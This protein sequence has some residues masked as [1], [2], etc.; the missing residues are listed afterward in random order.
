MANETKET[1]NEV[2]N[3][4]VSSVATVAVESIGER[5]AA[6]IAKLEAA[7]ETTSSVGVKLRNKL[8]IVMLETLSDYAVEK[9]MAKI[10]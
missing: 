8:Y 5:K 10:G 1:L 6:L 2:K 3:V 4:L 9:L 7:N